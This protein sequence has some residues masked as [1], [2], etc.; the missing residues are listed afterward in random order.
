MQISLVFTFDIIQT[1]EKW[2]KR[3]SSEMYVCTFV[4]C[5]EWLLLSYTCNVC[6]I[7]ALCLCMWIARGFFFK[8]F[9]QW[10]CSRFST[11]E[12]LLLLYILFFKL[13]IFVIK[14]NT[15]CKIISPEIMHSARMWNWFLGII[16]FIFFTV[17]KATWYSI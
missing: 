7:C 4:H 14:I 6:A 8:T 11:K 15:L 3:I 17:I 12:I 9:H 16:L 5:R 1:I 10:L 13:Y 2:I